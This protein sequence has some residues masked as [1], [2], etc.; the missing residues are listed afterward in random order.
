MTCLE[1]NRNPLRTCDDL[2]DGVI[3]I[4]G[5]IAIVLLI[6]GG[7]WYNQHR[8]ERKRQLDTIPHIHESVDEDSVPT[9]TIVVN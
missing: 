3:G 4:F 1:H 2:I 8:Y 6:L 9:Y 5:T 7:C